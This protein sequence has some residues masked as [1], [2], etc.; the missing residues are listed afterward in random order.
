MT[1]SGLAEIIWL[2]KTRNAPS[3]RI[4]TLCGLASWLFPGFGSFP[5]SINAFV[6]CIVVLVAIL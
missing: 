2:F 4:T 1:G 5:L 3:E 6:V